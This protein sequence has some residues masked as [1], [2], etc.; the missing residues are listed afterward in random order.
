MKRLNKI[1]FAGIIC[2][3]L[4]T[5]LSLNVSAELLDESL[6]RVVDDA[7]LL[8][9]N[10]EKS[11]ENQIK[12]I[13]DEYDFDVVLVTADTLGGK[14]PMEY[15]DDYYDYNGYGANKDCDGVLLLVSMEDR[16]WWISTTGY[17]IKAFT[18]YGID[19]AGEKFVSYLSNAEYSQGFEKFLNITE[20]YI[21]AAKQGKPYD[22]N[23][24]YLTK[25]EAEKERIRLEKENKKQFYGSII[26][27]FVIGF[28][29]ALI[30][31][32]VFKSQLKSVRFQ[33]GAA[34]YEVNGSLNLTRSNDVFLYKN[35]SKRRRAESSGGGHSGGGGGGSSTHVSS[36]GTTHGGGGGKF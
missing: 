33:G 15:A 23:N 3:L 21:T 6:P 35:V 12:A 9:E 14:S 20:D 10:E 28:V 26:G 27:C 31:V 24:V 17:G 16:D 25:E 32:L 2:L 22:I 19:K 1:L 34:N 8:T 18:D 13:T 5:P 7:D 36:S 29:A 11:L 4:M 30:T